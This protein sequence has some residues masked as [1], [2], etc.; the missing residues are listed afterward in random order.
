VNRIYFVPTTRNHKGSA[1][2]STRAEALIFQVFLKVQPNQ[3]CKSDQQT[4]LWAGA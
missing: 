1:A 3:I 2:R 4:S